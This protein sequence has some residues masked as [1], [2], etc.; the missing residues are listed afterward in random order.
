MAFDFGTMLS[1]AGS[2]ATM[3]AMAGPQG[4]IIG[5]LLGGIGGGF[6]G[7]PEDPINL[8][9]AN[10]QAFLA[11]LILNENNYM[12]QLAALQGQG[13]DSIGRQ[14]S[15]GEALANFSP[16]AKFD[17]SSAFRAFLGRNP[18]L[19]QLARST[20]SDRGGDAQ[21]QAN[22]LAS[23]AVQQVA[24]QFG[25][26]GV[27]SGGAM[28]AMAQGAAN[29]LA[30]F[31]TQQNQQFQNA[32]MSLM[33]QERAATQTEAQTALRNQQLQD[34]IR[35]SGLQGQLGSEQSVA[36]Q[37]AQSQ[38]LLGSLLQGLVAQRGNLSQQ[39][40]NTP[41]GTTQSGLSDATASAGYLSEVAQRDDWASM[42]AG[43]LGGSGA[44]GGGVPY[45]GPGT[46]LTQ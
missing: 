38:S 1:G 27:R 34:Q 25:G 18:A 41:V 35:F 37:L 2:G 19:Q 26:Q 3:G 23:Q 12:K 16:E 14:R 13:Q 39:I 42:L 15:L 36:G 17:E 10:T 30:Q 11:D 4:A 20:V 31:K 46:S 32:L 28:A 5:A 24:N 8:N 40:F 9:D 33:G 44:G 6:L 43:L 22:L 45:S 21:E 29:P 7:G